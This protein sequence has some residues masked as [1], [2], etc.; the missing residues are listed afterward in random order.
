M[1]RLLPPLLPLLF[2]ARMQKALQLLHAV[3]KRCL[4]IP[5]RC[6]CCCAHLLL[7]LLTER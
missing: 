1:L 5:E 3:Q 7:V 6:A 2:L 4:L